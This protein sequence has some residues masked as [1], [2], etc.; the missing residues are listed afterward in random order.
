M[1]FHCSLERLIGDV[2]EVRVQR[3]DQIGPRYWLKV[4]EVFQRHFY[5]AGEA[6]HEDGSGF[7][8]KL[9]VKSALKAP[10]SHRVI[11][12]VA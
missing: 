7:A 11:D 1:G 12:Q 6:P 2:L 8:L 10:P 3:N 5:A 4:R 9:L